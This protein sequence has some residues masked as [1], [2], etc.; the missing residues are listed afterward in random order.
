MVKYIISNHFSQLFN[1]S[2]LH[3]FL[4]GGEACHIM[5][6][7]VKGQLVK[8]GSFCHMGI[9]DGTQ[10]HGLGGNH[11]YLMSYPT[12]KNL[13]LNEAIPIKELLII[14]FKRSS[15]PL[16][17]FDVLEVTTPSSPY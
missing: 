5:H 7:R 2:Q 6:N 4:W 3:L 15:K 13:I 17:Y 12:P 11:F 8:V 14:P 16:F 1:D 10:V 9:K